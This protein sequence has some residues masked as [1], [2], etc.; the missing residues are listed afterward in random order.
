MKIAIVHENW[1]AGAARC[2][3]DL[4]AGLGARHEVLY[5]PRSAEE[6]GQSVLTGLNDFQPDVVNCHSFY[7]TLPYHLLAEFS[8]RYATVFTV[9]DPR[10]V[11]DIEVACWSCDRNDWCLR[12]PLIRGSWR[13]LLRNRYFRARARKRLTHRQCAPDLTIVTPSAWMATHLRQRELKRFRIEHIRNGI[14]LDRFRPRAGIRERFGLPQ[15]AT[16]ILHLAWH[17]GEW[18]VNERKGLRYLSQAFAETIAPK[19]ANAYLAVAGESYAPNHPRAIPL[20]MVAA[21]CLP[22]LLASID[23]FVSPTLAD[24][25]P[26]TV[27]EAMACGKP[28]IASSVGGIPEQVEH[29]KTGVLVPPGDA[30]ALGAALESLLSAPAR[31]R[32]YGQAGRRKAEAEVSM[33]EFL[34]AYESLFSEVARGGALVAG[35]PALAA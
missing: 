6:N 17:A 24:N 32:E 10:P 27:I 31:L 8:R 13:K 7:G 5:F 33:R 19:F 2:A 18:T 30:A 34:N 11:G 4:E 22:E 23:V 29:G 1:G 21:D 28:V 3:R 15:E 12:C 35:I 25:F 9:H 16:I 20:G 26:Y 14:D